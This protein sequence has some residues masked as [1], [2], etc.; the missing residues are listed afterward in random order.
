M[1]M[2]DI[3][4]QEGALEPEAERT[5]V[6]RVSGLLVEHELRRIVDLVDDPAMVEASVKRANSIAWMFVHRT[7]TYVAGQPVGP[8]APRGPVYK[9]VVSIP[10]GQIDEEFIAAINRDILQALTDAEDG[11]WKHPELRLWVFVHEIKDGTWG[12]AGMKTQLEDIVDFVAPGYGK[13][14]TERWENKQR[15]DAVAFIRR[16]ESDQATA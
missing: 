2:C 1:P 11:R 12:S 5:L 6:A 15:A 10:E 7:D 9:F 16:A 14:A 3:Y 8:S 13:L 4:I